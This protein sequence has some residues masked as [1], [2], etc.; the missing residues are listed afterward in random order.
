[1]SNENLIRIAFFV[2]VTVIIAMTVTFSLLYF[3]YAKYKR[4]HIKNGHEDQKLIDDLTGKKHSKVDNPNKLSVWWNNLTNKSSAIKVESKETKQS[5][6]PASYLE[7]IAKKEK[8]SKISKI[9]FL[10]LYGVFAAFIIA[11]MIT[12]ITYRVN[13]DM[14]FINDTTYLTIKT[15]SMSDVHKENTYI[16]ENN[17][18]NQI[19]QYALI[20]VKRVASVDELNIYDVVAFKANDLIYVHRLIEKNEG[21]D[22]E[23]LLTFKGDANN[24]SYSFEKGVSFDN[25]IGVYNGYQSLFWGTMITYLQSNIGIIA[26]TLALVFLVNLEVQEELIDCDYSKRLKYLATKL[27]KEQIN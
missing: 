5:E 20:N 16:Q 19:E 22:G 27:D 13:G 9:V 6:K 3:V 11:L 1:M 23:I 18:D 17:L 8:K 2:S 15:P 25:V 7:L 21:S 26:M 10:S 4:E 12:S 14:L 24:G